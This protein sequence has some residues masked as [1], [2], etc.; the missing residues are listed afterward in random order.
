MFDF[1]PL[2]GSGLD[3]LGGERRNSAQAALADQQM[4]FQERMSSSAHQREVADLRRA[5]LN[6]ML[7]I[8]HGG[9]GASSPPGAMASVENTMGHAVNTAREYQLLSAEVKLK[10]AQARDADAS[11]KVKAF[12]GNVSEA[13]SNAVD[14][15]KAGARPAADAFM[16]AV[17]P[18]VE[19]ASSSVGA[20]HNATV[21]KVVEAAE[22]IRDLPPVMRRKAEAALTNSA[23]KLK[24]MAED[25]KKSSSSGVGSKYRD[26]APALKREVKGKF[27]GKLGGAS[28]S[29][30]L[31][32]GPY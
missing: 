1:I 5:G 21:A 27:R 7:S 19:G 32:D 16:D 24:S 9:S 25:L 18:K 3:F 30:G 8:R 23:S 17:M 4:A 20:V 29:F 6:P 2:L 11:A 13:A 14:S 28:R 26:V 15:L 22:A 10:E 12:P 31:G